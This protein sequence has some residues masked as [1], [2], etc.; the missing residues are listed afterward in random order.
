MNINNLNLESITVDGVDPSDYPDFSDAYIDYAEWD[1]GLDLNDE[2]L[3]EL[4][5]EYPEL[6]QDRAFESLL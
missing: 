6:A 3:D 5:N 2:E 1:N 4:N